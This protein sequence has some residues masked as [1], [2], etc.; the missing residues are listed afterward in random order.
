[1]FKGYECTDED[2][3]RY[4]NDFKQW[5]KEIKK[6]GIDYTFYYNHTFATECIYKRLSSGEDKHGTKK[7]YDIEQVTEREEFY[8]SKCYNA[9]LVYCEKYSGECYGYDYNNYYPRMLSNERFFIPIRAGLEK[10]TN[11]RARMENNTLKYG[12]YYIHITS[13]NPDVKKIFSFSKHHVY[14][15]D[16]IKFAYKHRDRFNFKFKFWGKS[17]GVNSMIYEDDEDDEILK[18]GNYFFGKWFNKL[19]EMRLLYPK[20]KLIKNLLCSCWGCL[21]K[22]S[23]IYKTHDEIIKECINIDIDG[24]GEYKIINLI[25]KDDGEDYYELQKN[26]SPY[27]YAMARMKPFLTGRCRNLTANLCI[28]G[29]VEFCIRIH[30]DNCVFTRPY[31]VSDIENLYPEEKTT[32]NLNFTVINRQPTRN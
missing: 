32:G 31:D 2:L 3:L 22:K 30:T 10:Y 19:H 16:S 11:V 13:E 28:R 27:K 4:L 21:T 26:D 20:N 23:L 25:F 6:E 12:M 1:M 9:G 8:I 17:Y 24:E 15:H 29:G 14:T 18:N 7:K 5:I